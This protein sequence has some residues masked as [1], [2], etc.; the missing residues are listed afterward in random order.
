LLKNIRFEI[1]Q[2]AAYILKHLEQNGFEAYIVGGCVRDSVIGRVPQDWD[3]ASSAQPHE[4]KELFP[5]TIDTGIKHGTVTVLLNSQ[6]FEITTYRIEGRYINHRKP[7]TVEFTNSLEEDLGRRDFTINAM[8]YNPAKGLADPY[9]GLHDIEAKQIK[10]VGNAM[11]RFEEDALR[12]LRAVRF[13]AQLGYRIEEATLQA[14]SRH[15][16]LITN[17]SGERIRDEL[18][19]A[20]LANPMSFEILYS[21]GILKEILPEL[22]LCFETMQRHPYHI[23]N[24]GMHSLHA[25]NQTTAN[26]I[27]RWTMLLHDIGKPVVKTTDEK[28]IDHFYMHQKVSAQK[29]EKILQRLRF[30]NTSTAQIKKLILEHDRQIGDNEKSVRKAIAAI[31]LDLFQTWMQVRIADIKAQNPDKALERMT[32][33]DKVKA[34]YHRVIAEKQCLSLKQLAVTGNELMEIGIPQGKKL[35]EV[36]QHLLDAVLEQ[37]QLNERDVLLQM[38]RKMI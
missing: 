8:A 22:A 4:I 20:L 27:L 13:S 11:Q 3:I 37:P 35:G 29:A 19:K 18:S 6:P 7:E 5:K 9:K 33:L 21:T 12:M 26:L 28:G 14:I 31:G 24:V 17:I 34:I 23:Y 38:A 10:A 36:L 1:P 25:A 30:D 32:H 15:S 16:P 2:D